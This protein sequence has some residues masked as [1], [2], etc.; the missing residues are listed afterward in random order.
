MRKSL[1]LLTLSLA[2]IGPAAAEAHQLSV[3]NARA[4]ARF[5]AG[6]LVEEGIG[7]RYRVGSCKR[8]SGH[9]ISCG[10]RI[11]GP[12]GFRCGGRVR[13]AYLDHAS[14]DTVSRVTSDSCQT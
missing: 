12:G 13:T 6:T 3:S 9:A 8:H 7:T 10:F 1:L 2:M 14:S 5:Y 11:S 4:E